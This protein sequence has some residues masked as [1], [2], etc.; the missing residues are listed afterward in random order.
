MKR[1]VV[2]FIVLNHG[3]FAQEGNVSLSLVD[4]PV[5]QILNE[6]EAQSSYKI[7]YSTDWFRDYKFEGDWNDVD[8]KVALNQLLNP[9]D[10]GYILSGSHIIVLPFSHLPESSANQVK[11][12]DLT[13][14]IHLTDTRNDLFP[15]NSTGLIIGK[16]NVDTEGNSSVA[17]YVSELSNGEPIIGALVFVDDPF[18]G[19]TTDNQGF[20]SLSLP[21]GSHTLH[22][23]YVGLEEIIQPIELLSDGDANFEMTDDIVALK[24]ITIESER[25]ANINRVQLGLNRIDVKS[26]KNVPLVLGEPDVMKVAATLPGVQTVGEAATGYNVRGGAADQNLIQIDGATIYNP[27]HFFGF[28]SVLNSNVIK[29]LDLLKSSLP[30]Q[31]GGRLSSVFDLTMIEGNKKELSGSGTISVAT[32]GLTLQGPIAKDK[33]SFVFGARTTY[34]DWVL[35]L[36]PK[37]S[38]IRDSEASFFDLV[39]KIDHQIDPNNSISI[40]GYYSKDRF[41]LSSDSTFAYYN[42]NGSFL[43]RRN[44]NNRLI[45]E[46]RAAYNEYDFEIDFDENPIESFNSGYKVKDQNINLDFNY[47]INDRQKV[48]FGYQFKTYQVRPGSIKPVGLESLIESSSIDSEKAHEHSMYLSNDLDLSPDFSVYIGLRYSLFNALGPGTVNV[49][50]SESSRSNETVIDSLFFTDNDV[51]ETYHGPELRLGTRYFI[52]NE[53]SLKISYNRTRQ[54]IHRLTNTI[55]VAPTDTWKLSDAHIKPQ[56]GDQYSIG[57]FKNFGNKGIEASVE[58]YYKKLIN[59]LDYKDGADLSLNQNIESDVLQGDG[60]AFGVELFIKKKKGKFN[61]WLSYAYSRTFLRLNGEFPEEQING[62]E[63]FPANY[64]KPHSF[65]AVTNYRLTRRY[66][67]SGNLVYSTGRPITFP[68]AKFDFGGAE[69]IHFSKRNEFRIPDYFRVDIGFNIEGNHKRNKLSHSFWNISIYNVIGRK[70]VYS[71]FFETNAGQIEAK[72][73]SIFGAPI[74]TVT[75]HFE[76]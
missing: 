28:F 12:A 19:T 35:N 43:W 62:G 71:V 30:V 45:G 2:A 21:Q 57:L 48:D 11:D 49:Y 73:L 20:Y 41:R 69:K 1:L 65:N 70:N 24:E 18:I 50:S 23:Q 3:L 60:T 32:A 51:I 33:T 29:K 55:A 39:G 74:P 61:G 14:I 6:I 68:I 4:K 66:S 16:N 7:Y 37:S 72:Q 8:L 52:G 5:T 25:D 64:D 17:G 42:A 44:F 63:R 36:V 67:F 10:L 76:F 40:T 53:A 56:I 58:G 38:D 9:L 22:V 31:Y 13:P 54:Y 46:L 15:I 59:A 75:Y 34:S 47:F 27:A 26:I